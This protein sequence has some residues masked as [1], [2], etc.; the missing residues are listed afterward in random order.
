LVICAAPVSRPYIL[1]LS[2]GRSVVGQMIRAGFDT[3]LMEWG[4]ATAID[5]SRGLPDIVCGS[6]KDV[7]EFVRKRARMP[8]VHLLGYCLGG[9]LATIFTALYP[10]TVKTLILMAAP[11]DVG[12]DTSLV[13]IWADEN[14][15]DVDSFIERY[16]DRPGPLL[17]SCCALAR[18]VRDLYEQFS[19]LAAVRHDGPTFESFIALQQW[20]AVPVSVAGETLRDVVKS[21]YQRNQLVNGRLALGGAGVR[22]DRIACPVLILTARADHLAAPRSSEGL[23]TRIC[24]RDIKIMSLEGGHEGLTVGSRAHETFWPVASQ[25][26][27]DHST[28][29]TGPRPRSGEGESGR[30]GSSLDQRKPASHALPGTGGPNVRAPVF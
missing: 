2:P 14:E 30:P 11:I 9:T 8:R 28:P 29:G 12:Q 16:G 20:A 23:A 22:L 21:L 19:E 1:D 4:A 13:K 6:M 18:P 7:A 15:F 5:R 27:A 17:A 25:W 26:I 10:E 24:S 3:Y